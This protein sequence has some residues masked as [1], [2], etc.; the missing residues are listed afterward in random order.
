MS[1]NTE[2]IFALRRPQ[3]EKRTKRQLP[4]TGYWAQHRNGE[5]TTVWPPRA[6][7]FVLYPCVPQP[8]FSI[9]CLPQ[10]LRR[11][12][13]RVSPVDGRRGLSS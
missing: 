2:H 10:N 5:K 1:T 4:T 6:A 11:A 13:L 12:M 9:P 3:T 7:R 8:S